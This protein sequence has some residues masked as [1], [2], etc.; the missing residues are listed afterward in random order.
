MKKQFLLLTVLLF[1]SYMVFG[2]LTAGD[3]A[4]IGINTDNPDAFGFVALVDIPA[5]TT[6]YFTDN[7]VKSN[8][9]L[10]SSERTLAWSSPTIISKGTVVTWEGGSWST[11]IGTGSSLVF[12]ASGDQCIVYTGSSASPTFIYALNIANN[13][14]LTSGTISSKTSYLPPGLTNGTNAIQVSGKD[15]GY[16]SGTTTGTA[17]AL[18][19]A[20]S[21]NANWTISNTRLDISSWPGSFTITGGFSGP[22]NPAGFTASAAS[23]SQINLVWT[24]NSHGDNVMIAMNNSGSFGTPVNGTHY[25][26]GNAVPGGGTVIYNGN[27]TSFHHSGLLAGKHYYYKAW[28]VD[29]SYDYSRGVN[30]DATTLSNTRLI[31]SEVDD[32]KDNTHARFVELYNPSSTDSI[33]FNTNNVWYLAKQVNGGTFHDVQLRNDTIF[34]EE[35]YIVAASSASFYSAYGFN[36]DL[37][38]GNMNGN[39]DD[40]YFLYYGGD[41]LTGTLID[42]YGV[43][44]Q[45]GTG[46]PWEYSDSRV[47]RKSSVSQP[48][49]TWTASEWTKVYPANVADMVPGTYRN[50]IVWNGKTD[51][52][53]GTTGNWVGRNV[54]GSVKNIKIPGGAVHYP[55]VNGNTSS[56]SVVNSLFISPGGTLSIPANKA[57]TVNG[58]VINHAG[59]SGL[60]IESSGSGNGSLIIHGPV[61]GK[62]TVQRYIAKYTTNNTHNN[63]NGWHEI[64]CPVSSFAVSGTDWDPTGTNND[65]YYWDEAQN[66]WMNYKAN[67]FQFSAGQGYLV[68]NSSNTDHVFTGIPNTGDITVPLTYHATPGGNGWNFVANPY[69]SAIIWDNNN[70]S[71]PHSV[72]TTAEIWDESAGSYHPVLPGEII[73]SANGFFVQTTADVSLVIPASSR[74]HNN[75][76]NYKSYSAKNLLETLVFK[77]TDDANGFSDESVLGFKPNASEGWDIPY[78]AH[79]ILS[80]IESAPQIWTISKQQKFLVNYLPEPHSAYDVPIGFR[81]GVFTAYHLTIKGADSFKNVAFVLEDTKTGEKI[82]LNNTNSY[83]FTAGKGSDENRFVLHIKDITAVSGMKRVDDVHVFVNGHVVYLYCQNNLKGR[84]AIFNTLGQIIYHGLLNGTASQHIRLNQR[85][86]IYII[87]LEVHNHIITKK[88]F[89]K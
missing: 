45:D 6:I 2:Q 60:V 32:P 78:D 67:A 22:D 82:D 64:G 77:I 5:N 57:L 33:F 86:G 56:P 4:L 8:G 36:P 53:W 61:S 34:P 68:A 17:S 28:S 39:G 65:L 75:T 16:Y 69:T 18:L 11:G 63:G 51:S 21:N 46:Q 31:I 38:N 43:E 19:N 80:F 89:I 83:D 40:G 85:N 42:A 24:K 13:G 44:N 70:W 50:C 59:P 66:M 23:T 29:G 48:N 74:T 7:G 14:W 30:A 88:V 27:A 62:V 73:P 9:S 72:S 55:V 87:R 1:Y 15:N 26:A 20:I 41:H 37:S 79:K 71:I 47:F 58:N 54:P 81:A 35:T 25:S 3:I 84:I 12:N 52:R 10:S 49:A 76:N